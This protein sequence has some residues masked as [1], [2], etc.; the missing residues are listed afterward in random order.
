MNNWQYLIY[1]FMLF[2]LSIIYFKIAQKYKIV[3]LPN[4]R[5]MHQGATIRGGGIIIFIGV[6]LFS[7]TL[8]EPSFF[9]T[10]GLLIIGITGFLDDLNDLSSKIRIPIQVLSILLILADLNMLGSNVILLM[11]IIVVCTGIL[12]AYNFMDGINGITGGYSLLTVLSMTY[13]NNYIQNFIANQFLII[14]ILTLLVFNFFN[15]RNKAVCFAGDVGSLAV[16]FVIIY[17]MIKLIN[18]SNEIAYIL[19]LTLYGIDTI[20]TIIQRLLMKQ[21]IFEA[22]RLHLFQVAISKT[23]KPHLFMTLIYVAVQ[24]IINFIVILTLPMNST[25][26]AVYLGIML[27]I[28]S[29]TYVGV[30]RKL[31]IDTI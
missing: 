29:L 22:H 27:M 6:L 26:Q 3:D 10:G 30:K 12:N 8:D 21:N 14:I 11:I 20:F 19:F 16:A 7:L 18:E 15:F 2:G 9:F 13:V 31:M 25:Q 24:A 5:T 17:L 28:L 1:T 23:G 4:H